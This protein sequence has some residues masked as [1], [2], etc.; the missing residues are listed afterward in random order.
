LSG[1]RAGDTNTSV[2]RGAADVDYQKVISVFDILQRVV[3]T[4]VGLA[5]VTAP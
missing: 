4:K 3:I 2:V 5:T 1:I